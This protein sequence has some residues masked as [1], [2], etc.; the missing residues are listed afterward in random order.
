[1]AL[2]TTGNT[3]QYVFMYSQPPHMVFVGDMVC[4]LLQDTESTDM[5]ESMTIADRIPL[6]HA[7]GMVQA[8]FLYSRARKMNAITKQLPC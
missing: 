1:M 8:P 7:P 6:P 4:F 2:D 5:G 3:T